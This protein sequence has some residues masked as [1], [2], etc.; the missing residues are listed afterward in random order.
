M[1]A[2][3]DTE[4]IKRYVEI[5]M[6]VAVGS[7]FAM[8]SEDH[9]RIGMVRIDHLFPGSVIGICTLKGKFA[10]QAVSNFIELMSDQM[11]GYRP[12]LWDW[13]TNG[14]AEGALTPVGSDQ[15]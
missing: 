6:G 13:E 7:D 3:D 11:R 2:L 4:S 12:E 9:N 10:G 14:V 15:P 8:H 1:L 5:G